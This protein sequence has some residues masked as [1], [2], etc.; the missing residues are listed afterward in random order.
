MMYILNNGIELHDKDVNSL[1]AQI[2][3][4][5][6]VFL[7]VALGVAIM[8]F[9]ILAIWIAINFWMSGGDEQKTQ[10]ARNHLKNLLIGLIAML[11]IIGVGGVVQ[12]ILSRKINPD[13]NHTAFLPYPKEFLNYT[14]VRIQTLIS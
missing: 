11:I 5:L 14:M 9:I 3:S 10:K 7:Q 12:E 13:D 1:I 6:K 4:I 2:N 8:G